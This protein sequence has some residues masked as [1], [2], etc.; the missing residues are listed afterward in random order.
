MVEHELK[1][2][3]PASQRDVLEARRVHHRP[4]AGDGGR[5]EIELSAAD[6]DDTYIR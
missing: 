3:E 2:G 4:S 1:G 6:S 5:G